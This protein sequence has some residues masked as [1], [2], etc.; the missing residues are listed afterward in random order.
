[1]WNSNTCA[2]LLC[3]KNTN[4]WHFVHVLLAGWE[5]SK[6]LQVN[7]KKKL[8]K[9]QQIEKNKI[10]NLTTHAHSNS[11]NIRQ[12]R[13]VLQVVQTTTEMDHDELYCFFY[14]EWVLLLVFHGIKIIFHLTLIV[15]F[16]RFMRANKQ[17]LQ[18]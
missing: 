12:Y 4:E 13:N 14:F 5:G 3:S 11:Y 18:T 1:M 2:S 7:K 15:Q 10:L 16:V 8:I 6:G 9:H 17:T